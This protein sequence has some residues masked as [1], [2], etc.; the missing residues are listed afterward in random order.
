MADCCLQRLDGE[1]VGGSAS[2]GDLRR[3]LPGGPAGAVAPVNLGIP[4]VTSGAASYV[5]PT[6]TATLLG[7]LELERYTSV[8]GAG[9]TSGHRSGSQIW[10]RGAFGGFTIRF[11]FHLQSFDADFRAFVGLRAATAVIPAV[12][13]STLTDILGMGFDP[14][15]AEWASMHNDAAGAAVT[16]NLGASYAPN[17]TDVLAL[18]V[19]AQPSGADY[20]CTFENLTVG[21]AATVVSTFST[22][23]PGAA[24]FLSSNI[25]YNTGAEAA[26]ACII[27][28]AEIT[29]LTPPR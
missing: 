9:S 13:P 6:S 1:A 28:M 11:V 15:G 17:T 20:T 14:A 3:L 21:A 12:N 8:V 27:D 18:T 24:L 23:I 25:W 26:T 22:D 29:A 5:A 2:S 10:G 4:N 16:A 7:T 19:T